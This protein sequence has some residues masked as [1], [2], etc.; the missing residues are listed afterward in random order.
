M[1]GRLGEASVVFP[2]LQLWSLVV[3]SAVLEPRADYLAKVA[4]GV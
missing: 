4:K 3:S 2:T 1:S